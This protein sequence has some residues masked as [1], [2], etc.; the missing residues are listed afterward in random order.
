STSGYTVK[1]VDEIRV[2]PGGYNGSADLLPKSYKSKM[3]ETYPAPPAA[4]PTPTANPLLF[5]PIYA[6]VI[7]SGIIFFERCKR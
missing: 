5:L 6:I 2:Y 1:W 4:Q 3:D 7:V